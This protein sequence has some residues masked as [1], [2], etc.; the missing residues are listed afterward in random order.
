MR[1]SVLTDGS[2][3]RA[4]LPVIRWVLSQSSGAVAE[5]RWADLRGQEPPPRTLTERVL[6]AVAMFPCEILFVHRDAEGEPRARRAEEIR[7]ACPNE[8]LHVCVV[9]VRMQEAW[10]LFDEAAIREA[11]GRPSNRTPLDLPPIRQL[12]SV[13]DPKQVLHE[14]LRVA[15]GMRGRRARS[16][17]PASAVHRVADLISDWAPLRGL[18]AFREFEADT[19]RAVAKPAR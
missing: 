9:P 11:A 4:L 10:L 3:D 1:C 12:E 5:L 8:V 17:S 13:A 7:A 2:S 6:A 16:F 19:L 15:S 18:A 14:A